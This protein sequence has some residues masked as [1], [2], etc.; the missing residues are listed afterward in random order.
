MAIINHN[1]ISGINTISVGSSIVIGDNFVLNANGI[2]NVNGLN[3]SGVVT[4]SSFVGDGSSL[5]G[6][7]ATA[8]KDP[9]GNVIIQA[10]ASG[11]NVTGV[12]TFSDEVYFG[13][14]AK[15]T[16][17]G[18]NFT[19]EGN[20]GNSA[21]TYL[22]GAT[23]YIGAN[24]GSGSYSNTVVVREASGNQLV[25][26]AYAGST[27]LATTAGGI[28][29]TGN[30]VASGNVTVGGTL[31]YEDVTNVDSIGIATARSGLRVTGGGLE[32]TGV[33]TFV[34][35]VYFK[36]E[37]AGRDAHWDASANSLRF[38]DSALIKVGTGD[39]LQIYH[40]AGESYIREFGTGDLRISGQNI[41]FYDQNVIEKYAEF[42]KDGAVNLYF[43]NNN[44]FGTTAT[45]VEITGGSVTGESAG[46]I[47]DIILLAESGT[48]S[49]TGQRILFKNVEQSW[50][51]GAITAIR[52]GAANSF[53]LA[54]SSSSGGTNVERLRITSGGNIG[55]G[56]DN[57]D[58]YNNAARNL[59]IEGGTQTGLTIAT[60]SLTGN[61]RIYFA[62]STGGSGDRAGQ[63]NYQ[64]S[65]N[66][67]FFATDGGER[68]R[69]TSGGAIG[70]GTVSP[71]QPNVAGMHIHSTNNDDCRI[72]FS[73]PN[74]P[75][76]RIGYYGL[77]NNFGIDVQNGFQIRDAA[78]SNATR[79]YIDSSGNFNVGTTTILGK[80]HFAGNSSNRTLVVTDDGTSN[81]TR[82]YDL[83]RGYGYKIGTTMY[84]QAAVQ[85]TYNSAS[86]RSELVFLTS[87]GGA[88]AGTEYLRLNSYGAIGLSGENYGTSGQVL[89][90]QGTTSAP[91]WSSPATPNNGTLTINQGGSSKGTFT[92]NQSGNT[93]V[94]L[95]A[96][97]ATG[98]GMDKYVIF[99]DSG[100]IL[101]SSNISSVSRTN[102]GRYTINFSGSFSNV[103]Y[104][105]LSTGRNYS[106]DQN[107]RSL[108]IYSMSTGSCNVAL[109]ANNNG[110]PNDNGGHVAFYGT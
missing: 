48:Q 15:A 70:I 100:T 8:L 96:G 75:S 4:A 103:N 17:G 97:N 51:Q 88:S 90:S 33:S 39:D 86:N 14:S 60:N 58:G 54:L 29:V 35:D 41:T 106:T 7:D 109:V 27:K 36:G 67:M 83:L 56:T 108:T 45:G 69:I 76:S 72:A 102:A 61:S 89:T 12:S 2:E 10:E 101:S 104:L 18:G 94:N 19:L 22:R 107:E 37:T 1:S 38:A 74:K 63:I 82:T 6:I 50:E 95:D 78:D 73:T 64:H 91:Q 66:V 68:L 55:I 59:V 98:L 44:K 84:G 49:S 34:D 105:I 99:N 31:I 9:D 92:A 65:D 40:V 46:T 11:I 26:L 85:S 47:R 53:S 3:I 23:V 42:V 80:A 32:V 13:A 20:I 30:I 24:G 79:L 16:S 43:D 81:T 110:G 21:G 25:E 71:E 28:D 87:T 93:T 62:D 77:S 57:P 52:E 5:T